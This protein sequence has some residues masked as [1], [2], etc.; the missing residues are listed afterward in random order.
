MHENYLYDLWPP[1]LDLTLHLHEM[2][3]PL[4]NSQ[5]SVPAPS[6]NER[7]VACETVEANKAPRPWLGGWSEGGGHEW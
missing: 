6:A 5:Q 3:A 2:P 1:W 7:L 4:V